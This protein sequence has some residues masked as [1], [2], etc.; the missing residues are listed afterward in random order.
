MNRNISKEQYNLQEPQIVERPDSKVVYIQIIG[1]YG[2]KEYN[3]VWD[4]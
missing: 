1:Q 3:G 2:N 4:M